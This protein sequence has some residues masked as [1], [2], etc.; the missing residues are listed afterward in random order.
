MIKWENYNGGMIGKTCRMVLPKILFQY[1]KPGVL[2]QDFFICRKSN[3]S[4]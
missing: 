1:Q 4:F 2:P 3:S